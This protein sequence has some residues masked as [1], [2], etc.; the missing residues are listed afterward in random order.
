[1][2]KPSSLVFNQIY[3]QF[4]IQILSMTYYDNIILTNSKHLKHTIHFISTT[5]HIFDGASAIFNPKTL[6][7]MHYERT[8]LHYFTLRGMSDYM[9]DTLHMCP[10]TH[11][12]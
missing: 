1:M 2:I 5:L 6:S 11:H 12:A 10:A 7:V 3:I 4:Y 9:L 8:Y